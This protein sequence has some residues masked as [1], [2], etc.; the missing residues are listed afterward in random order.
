[1]ISTRL[2]TENQTRRPRFFTPRRVPPFPVG[3]ALT[4]LRGNRARRPF[5]IGG[6]PDL[7]KTGDATTASVMMPHTAGCVVSIA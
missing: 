1:M 6:S 3:D 7:L 5:G 4:D 2:D